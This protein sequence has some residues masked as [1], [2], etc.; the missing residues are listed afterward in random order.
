MKILFSG[1]SK[2][3]KLD[4]DCT[5]VKEYDKIFI[6]DGKIQKKEMEEIRMIIPDEKE[7][8]DY[9]VSA[10]KENKKRD[11]NSYEFVTNLKEGNELFIRKRIEG[12]KILPIGMENY[13]KLKEIMI[14]SKIPKEE[15]DKIPVIVFKDEIVWAAGV[16]KSKKFI[17]EKENK[18]IVLRIRRKYSV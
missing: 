16:R 2:K 6:V 12:D 14:N 18:N 17:S 9:V 5:L 7:F 13:K 1:G 8:G 11:E 4:K 3:I 10:L 15:R